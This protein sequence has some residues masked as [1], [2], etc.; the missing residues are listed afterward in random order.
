MGLALEHCFVALLL[1]TISQTLPSYFLEKNSLVFTGKPS[2]SIL[3]ANICFSLIPPLSEM[4]F[5]DNPLY[6]KPT[7][8]VLLTYDWLLCHIWLVVNCLKS[9]TTRKANCNYVTVTL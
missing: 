8:L 5:M 7:V 6:C 4:L 1:A 3:F 2:P 9:K